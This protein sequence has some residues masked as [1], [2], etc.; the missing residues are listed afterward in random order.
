VVFNFGVP[1]G[2]P[3]IE[4]LYAKR[5]LA[6]GVRPDLLLLEILPPLLDGKQLLPWEAYWFTANRLRFNEGFWVQKYGFPTAEFRRTWWRT[7]VIPWYEE[8]FNILSYVAPLWLPFSVGVEWFTDMDDCGWLPQPFRKVAPEFRRTAEEKVRRQFLP[9]LT[10]FRLGGPACRAMHDLLAL[11]R[12]KGIPAALVLMPEGQHFRSWYPA[13]ALVQIQSYLGKLHRHFG[14]PVI[15]ART[16]IANED[17]TD[18]HHL[19]P[20]GATLFSRRL[21]RHVRLILDRR[22]AN[23]ETKQAMRTGSFLGHTAR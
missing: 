2:G 10:G 9:Y 3:V 14:V 11:S 13:R 8:R 5:L 23:E 22:R 19:M 17:F 20:Q 16:W 21:E 6:E 1:G 4:L 15:D 12:A 18:S 7:W